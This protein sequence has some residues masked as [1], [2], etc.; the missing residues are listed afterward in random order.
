MKRVLFILAALIAVIG[1]SAAVYVYFFANKPGVTVTANQTGGTNLPT[2]GQTSVT[3]SSST[4][5]SVAAPSGPLSA[6]SRIVQISAGPVVPGE[7]VTDS[8]SGAASSTSVAVQFLDRQSGNVFTYDTSSGGLTRTN[9]KTIPG[10]ESATWLPDASAAIVRFLSGTDLSTINTYL[11]SA[12]SSS[13]SFLTQGLADVSASKNG[14]LT[15]ASTGS[16]S[17]G[18]LTR[19]DGSHPT[20]VF[21][22][23]LSSIRAAAAGKNY[24]VFTKPAASIAGSAYLVNAS[25][26]F[27]GIA[28][29]LNG[30]VAL[31]SP[32]GE[33]VLVSYTLAGA[34]QME[35]VDTKTGTALPLPVATIADKCVWTNDST[36][37]YC[38]VPMNPP[39]T[40]AYPDDW[41]QGAVSFSDRIWKIDVS[42]RYAQLVLDFTTEE[43]TALDAEALAVDPANTT[44]VFVNKIDGSLWG[45]SL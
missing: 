7:I 20:I 6:T 12:T 18:T 27:T 14:I 37:I 31:P 2:A 11:L 45:Y 25:G 35:V 38:G 34:L 16:G 4:P 26:H 30:L 3:P 22:T 13:G 39:T 24:L 40:Y 23:P 1:V 44:L 32:S 8:K 43:K 17:T 42:G 36:S 21:S 15:V 10:I 28:G 33:W 19:A 29:P 41:Y 9:N 5:S